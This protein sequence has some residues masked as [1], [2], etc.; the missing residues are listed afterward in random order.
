MAA[1]RNR[2]VV[3]AV[4]TCSP[5][6][7]GPETVTHGLSAVSSAGSRKR[8]VSYILVSLWVATV[9]IQT[10]RM[11]LCTQHHTQHFS[12][13]TGNNLSQSCSSL[14]ESFC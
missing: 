10:Q 12:W 2:L 6:V 11:S 8:F 5:I 3:M 9:E 7:E 14:L 4:A 13:M 1:S